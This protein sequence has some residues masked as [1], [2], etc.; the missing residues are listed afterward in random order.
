MGPAVK[1]RKPMIHGDRKR[2]AARLSRRCRPRRLATCGRLVEGGLCLLLSLV[3]CGLGG[4]PGEGT[5]DAALPR[6]IDLGAGAGGGKALGH[7]ERGVVVVDRLLE[8]L[9]G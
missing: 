7:V 6:R 4:L 9:V 3:Q 5:G 1:I 2:Y 8:A